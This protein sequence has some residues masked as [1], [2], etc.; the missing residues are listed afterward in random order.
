M[1][2]E[3]P[4]NQK[5]GY[6]GNTLKGYLKAPVTGNY[7]FYVSCDDYC[8]VS[9]GTSDKDPSTLTEIYRSTEWTSYRGY[10]HP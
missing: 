3:T 8:K 10:I 1:T 5:N 6:S 2:T 4:R 7:R 9:L